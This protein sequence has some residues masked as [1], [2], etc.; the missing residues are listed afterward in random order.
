[1][2]ETATGAFLPYV[3]LLGDGT[4]GVMKTDLP[5]G[6]SVVEGMTC[7]AEFRDGEWVVVEVK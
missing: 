1:M 2:Q 4:K 6:T 5:E 3:V 7:V